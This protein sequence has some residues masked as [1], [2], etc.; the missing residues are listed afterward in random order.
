MRDLHAPRITLFVTLVFSSASFGSPGCTAELGGAEEDFAVADSDLVAT[1]LPL[2]FDV[3]SY[4]CAGRTEVCDPSIDKCLCDLELAHLNY[5]RVAA[6]GTVN[7]HFLVTGGDRMRSSVESA[8][9]ALAVN[10][11]ELNA[12]WTDGADARAD[13][14]MAWAVER[15][16]SEPPAW[17]FLNE[18]SRSRWLRDDDEG[19]RYRQYVVGVARRLRRTHGRRVV[20]FS[21]YWRP[22]Y[23]GR[24]RFRTAWSNLAEVSFIGVENYISGEAMRA[25]GFSQSWARER[26]RASIAA[27]TALG[28]PR[29][30]LMLTEHFGNTQPG[31]NFGRAGIRHTDW[32][33]A[34]RV[35]TRAARSLP[36]AG[37]ISYAWGSN[38]T[39]HRS[40]RRREAMDAYHAVGARRLVIPPAHSSSA[41]P[42]EAPFE[43]DDPTPEHDP[44]PP[45]PVDD[46]LPDDPSPP[47]PPP[48]C[49]PPHSVAID[50]VCVPSCGAAGGTVCTT[51]DTG[52]CD[53]R[54][55]LA[56]YDCPVC[57]DATEP[58]PACVPASCGS[59]YLDLCGGADDGCGGTL[60]CGDTCGD[61]LN[62]NAN[63]VCRRA[64]GRACAGPGQCASGLCQWTTSAGS[65][66][67]CCHAAGQWCDADIKCCQSLVCR[68]GRCVQP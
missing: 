49:D 40:D 60:R 56:S 7:G 67:R 36:F 13:A 1:R 41:P 47:E 44:E 42:S 63:G 25:R 26:Y 39:H 23:D 59:G 43:G 30:K 61:G 45:P 19:R 66:A 65:A 24:D 4:R 3:G 22:G 28:V 32:I 35:R 6:D 33:R 48:A 46:P 31:T 20:V 29:A 55:A 5:L 68:G 2:E 38:L 62:C 11:N 27:Y 16:G 14:M 54:P 9:N 57:C 58:A 12:H 10:I 34:I 17:F 21:P 8:G 15:F 53:G 50:G 37:F 64:L 18:I 51:A 52:I